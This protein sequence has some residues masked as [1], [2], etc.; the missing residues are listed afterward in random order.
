MSGS[1]LWHGAANS[2]VISCRSG[3]HWALGGGCITPHAG[4][5]GAE[6]KG[7][8]PRQEPQESLLCVVVSPAVRAGKRQMRGGSPTF[9]HMAIAGLAVLPG[10][11]AVC[12]TQRHVQSRSGQGGCAGCG[13]ANTESVLLLR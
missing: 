2:S 11:K 4:L 8:A 12:E 9:A 5:L 1:Q 7:S 10:R 6:E 3:L 13:T